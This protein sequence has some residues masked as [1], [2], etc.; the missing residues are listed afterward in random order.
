M[1]ITAARVSSLNPICDGAHAFAELAQAAA[2]ISA[3]D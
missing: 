1:P 3:F 2:Q